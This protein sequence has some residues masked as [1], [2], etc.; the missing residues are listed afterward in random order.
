MNKRHYA[1]LIW[2][3]AYMF[4]KADSATYYLGSLWWL[5]EPLIYLSAFYII[6]GLVMKR[7]DGIEFVGFLLC[8]LV[9][10][11]WFSTSIS[12]S[13]RSIVNNA[14]LINQIY[15]PK[16]VF[17]LIDMACCT[18]RFAM[19]LAVFLPFMIIIAGISEV[20]LALPLVMLMQAVFTVG[21]G[22]FMSFMIPIYPD[23]QKVLDNFM[24]LLFY[25]SGVFFDI[26]KSSEKVQAILK[27]N[28]MAVLLHEYRQILLYGQW[29]DWQILG[30]IGLFS[31]LLL[32]LSVYLLTLYDRKL[33]YYLD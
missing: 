27:L 11:K 10:F 7:G 4:L 20:W 5:L 30:T 2:H 17:P 13:A 19:V 31:A 32:A 24:M 6:F 26:S 12:M 28:P 23:L 16:V 15:L 33:P 22:L 1:S 21:A 18:L 14:S 9:Y 3:R 25:L 8:G 29:P